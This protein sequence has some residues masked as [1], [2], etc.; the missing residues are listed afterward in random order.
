MLTVA[1]SRVE[2]RLAV[3]RS[4]QAVDSLRS[5]EANQQFT[6][7]RQALQ[8]RTG[9]SGSCSPFSQ[10]QRI[11]NPPGEPRASSGHAVCDA[12]P[13]ASLLDHDTRATFGAMT[14]T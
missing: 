7:V 5:F 3:L 8:N 9:P 2:R 11:G 14:V 12:A 6:G 13:L 1:L 4:G 10:E